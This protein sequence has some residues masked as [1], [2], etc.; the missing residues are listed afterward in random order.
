MKKKLTITN[1]EK[2][3]LLLFGGAIAVFLIYQFAYK[4]LMEMKK[5][6]TKV[7]Q[8][9][10]TQ[11][12]EMKEIQEKES[13]YV[14]NTADMNAEIEAI[15]NAIPA[16]VRRDDQIMFARNMETFYGIKVSG[17]SINSGNEVYLL[18]AN[19]D[20]PTDDGK[21][22]CQTVLTI[23]CEATYNTL[24]DLIRG[25]KQDGKKM[26]IQQMN[27]EPNQE[28]GELTG[29]IIINMYYLVGGD[30]PYEPE[31]IPELSIGTPNIFGS[32]VVTEST[33]RSTEN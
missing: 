33:M 7:N 5:Q 20:N 29:S 8:T 31:Y 9:L 1:K 4:P 18:N 2:M 23:N 27:F 12:N 24:K 19:G 17:L 25:L 11:I 22:L 13:I 10:E 21:V 28:S 3:L 15:F 26:S 30:K 6:Q 14:N 16:Q 32:D